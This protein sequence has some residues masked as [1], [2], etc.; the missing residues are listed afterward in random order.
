M[1]SNVSDRTNHSCLTR[2]DETTHVRFSE[3]N[4][5]ATSRV[6]DFVWVQITVEINGKVDSYSPHIGTIFIQFEAEKFL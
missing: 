4:T 3:N 5:N 6:S 2:W 1:C